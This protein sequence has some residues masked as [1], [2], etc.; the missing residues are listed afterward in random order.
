M[1]RTVIFT[2]SQT[3]EARS[4]QFYLE[5]LGYQTVTVSEEICLW[6]EKALQVFA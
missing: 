2:G 1:K 3:A 6:D 5:T 4:T